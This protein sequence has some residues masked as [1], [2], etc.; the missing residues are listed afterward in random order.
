MA[1]V[2]NKPFQAIVESNRYNLR[3]TWGNNQINIAD[4]MLKTQEQYGDV[5]SERDFDKMISVLSTGAS[6]SALACRRDPTII[7]QICTLF[8]NFLNTKNVDNIIKCITKQSYPQT[9]IESISKTGYVFTE[10]QVKKLCS[11]GYMMLN[12]LDT[13]SFQEFI[14]LFNNADFWNTFK[15]NLDVDYTVSPDIIDAKI[16]MLKDICDKFKFNIEA[17]FALEM[18]TKCGYY[19][20]ERS[21]SNSVLNIHI[22]ADKLG[23]PFTSEY[24]RKIV[25]NYPRFYTQTEG[26]DSTPD[27]TRTKKIIKYYGDPVNREFILDN[28]KMGIDVFR[29]FLNPSLTSYDPMEDIFYIIFKVSNNLRY[30]YIQHMLDNNYLKYDNFLLFL[31]Y[32]RTECSESSL[33]SILKEFIKRNSLNIE[34]IYIENIFTFGNEKSINLLSDYKILPSIDF[35]KMSLLCGTL[36]ALR[37]TSLFLDDETENYID[38]ALIINNIHN[39]DDSDNRSIAV[40]EFVEICDSMNQRDRDI[41]LRLPIDMVLNV[42]TMVRYR[43]TLTKRMVEYMLLY[44]RWTSLISLM[45]MSKEY[46][47]IIEMLDIESI[48][49]APSFH[50]RSWMMEN[51]YNQCPESFA[52]PNKFFD[53]QNN[54]ARDVDMLMKQPILN[55]IIDIKATAQ[56]SK[57]EVR[58]RLMIEHLESQA[59]EEDSNNHDNPLVPAYGPQ[60]PVF[61]KK[62]RSAYPMPQNN[63]DVKVAKY[64]DDYEDDSDVD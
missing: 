32:I 45:Y 38:R 47:Y 58:R 9:C 60:S 50:A 24:F 5:M 61:A 57:E 11:L 30:Q 40:E 48:M 4:C 13:M 21:A 44:G 26:N 29:G 33:Y 36:K 20:N 23:M 59:K 55:N 12:L 27:Y 51:I 56:K 15:Q 62:E 7:T 37:G 3:Y 64:V 34:Q 41:V 8:P 10:S 31:M 28:L 42:S 43:I 54:V 1:L 22:I 39:D 17:N 2:M 6:S 52:I 63:V 25:E 35:V 19:Y 18:V 16:K 46:D 14:G 53:L 49:L